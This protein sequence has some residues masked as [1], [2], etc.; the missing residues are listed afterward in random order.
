MS[1]DLPASRGRV[2]KKGRGGSEGQ[3][4]KEGETEGGSRTGEGPGALSYREARLY[5]TC[6]GIPRVPSYATADESGLHS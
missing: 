3:S 6:S 1:Y 4:H 2:G 5:R